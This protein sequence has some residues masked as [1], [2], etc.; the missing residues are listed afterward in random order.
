MNLET[1]PPSDILK[2]FIKTFMIIESK[3]G[4]VN[5][6][7][8][9]TSIVMAFR[10]KGRVIARDK[11]DESSL[12]PSVVTGLRNTSRLID[13]SR[14]SAT[15]L[16]IFNEGGAALFFDEP[17]HKMFGLH[18]PMDSLISRR[19]LEETEEKI[20]EAQNNRRKIMIV[21]RFLRSQM[22][23]PQPDSLIHHAIQKIKSAGGDIRIGDLVTELPISLDPF[24]KRFRRIAGTSPKQFSRIV[25]LR[26]VINSYSENKSLTETAYASGYYDQSHF[27]KDFKSFT[28]QSPK[29]FFASPTFW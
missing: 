17:L 20:A 26:N 8:P 11:G 15:L 25:R 28:G 27:T 18:I 21:E 5:R 22:K 23:D 1:Y 13:Y 4:T 29:K 12:A 6:I 14:K 7:L 9:G 16:V 10:L 3:E 19:K 24:E 2:P